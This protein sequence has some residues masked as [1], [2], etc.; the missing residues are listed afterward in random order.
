VVGRAEHIAISGIRWDD[1]I[2]AHFARHDVT[3]E[4]VLEV[5]ASDPLTYRNL[6]GRGGSH[7]LIGSDRRGRV[8]YISLRRTSERSIREP[9]T[10]WESRLARRLWLRE[11]GEP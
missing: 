4:Q 3:F 5:L 2:D 1:D 10:G 9:V 7:V 8:L 11:R 6:E